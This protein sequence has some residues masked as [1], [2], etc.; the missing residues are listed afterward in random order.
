MADNSGKRTQPV[1]QKQPNAWGLHDMLGNV[2]EWVSDWYGENYY[3]TLVIAGGRPEGSVLRAGAGGAR[4]VLPRQ[5]EG[6]R[7]R[8]SG[9]TTSSPSGRDIVIG[10]RCVRE[11][12]P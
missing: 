9:R 4:R 6:P 7:V 3:Q 1:K 2:W 5:R 11:V 12:I 8:V 10:F